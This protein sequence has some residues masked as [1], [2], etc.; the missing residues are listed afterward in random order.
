VKMFYRPR[1]L[2]GLFPVPPFEVEVLVV[3][4]EKNTALISHPIV[5][6]I[7]GLALG[8]LNDATVT[9][10]VSRSCLVHIR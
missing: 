4:F 10:T 7:L 8:S 9:R 2:F 1:P 3:D 6:T 5:G